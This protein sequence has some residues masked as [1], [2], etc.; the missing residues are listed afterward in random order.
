MRDHITVEFIDYQGR[1]GGRRHA[2]QR[3]VDWVIDP[4][5]GEDVADMLRSFTNWRSTW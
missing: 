3:G 1:S 2:V 4:P 5:R